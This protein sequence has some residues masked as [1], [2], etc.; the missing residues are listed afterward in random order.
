[1][2]CVVV[3]VLQSLGTAPGLPPRAPVVFSHAVYALVLIAIMQLLP[4]ELVP[5]LE[6]QR[7]RWWWWWLRLSS[8]ADVP[9]GT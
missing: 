3:Q 5:A 8:G 6:A 7:R 2:L 9:G 4:Q 1:V